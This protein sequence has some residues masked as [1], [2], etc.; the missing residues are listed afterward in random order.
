[1]WTV[2]HLL[3]EIELPEDRGRG[4]Y[5]DLGVMDHRVVARDMVEKVKKR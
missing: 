3:Q 4:S 1:M 2:A 5:G